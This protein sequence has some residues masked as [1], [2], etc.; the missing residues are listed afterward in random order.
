MMNTNQARE[1]NINKIVNDIWDK[2]LFEIPPYQRLYEWEEKQIETL[3]EDVKKAQKAQ[4]DQEEKKYFIGNIVVSKEKGRYVLIDGQQ[5]LTTLFL[6]GIYLAWSEKN[7]SK[8]SI[9]TAP[10][11][12]LD[13]AWSEKN[14][15]KWDNFIRQ[16]K[17]LRITMPLRKE[18]ERTLSGLID[19]IVSGE[20]KKFQDALDA[21]PPIHTKKGLE[22]IG[23]WFETNLK[24]QAIDLSKFSNF[25]YSNVCFAFVELAKGTDLNRFF[26]RMNNRGKQLEKHEIL[27][28]RLLSVIR[29]SDKNDN[30]KKDDWKK[31][32]KIWDLCSDMDKYIFALEEDRTVFNEE[33]DQQSK[34]KFEKNLCKIIKLLGNSPQ[35]QIKVT[36]KE[37]SQKLKEIIKNAKSQKTE[38][39]NP[40]DV[41]YHSIIDFPTFL[42]HCYKLFF[43]QEKC[44]HKGKE[45]DIKIEKDKLLG[46]MWD[47]NVLLRNAEN[48]K[49]FIENFLLYRF[50]FDYFIIKQKMGDSYLIDWNYIKD[51]KG[52]EL[53]G[54]INEELKSLVMV[55]NYLR[56]ARAGEKQNYHH[57]LSYALKLSYEFL[58]KKSGGNNGGLDKKAVRDFLKPFREKLENLDTALALEQMQENGGDL[59]KVANQWLEKET[60]LKA[61]NFNFWAL[62]HLN[63]GTATPHYWF[64]RLEYYLWKNGRS[65]NHSTDK[66]PKIGGKTFSKIRENYCFRAL[67]SV[68]HI[69]P[70][71]EKGQWKEEEKKQ[72][73]N[74]YGIDDFGNLALISR[75]FNSSLG[76]QNIQKKFVDVQERVKD[77][78]VESL[79]MCLAYVTRQDEQW[80]PETAKKHQSEMLD[81]LCE[82]FL[83]FFNCPD[84]F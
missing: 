15:S 16:N 3:L 17:T 4:K 8:K 75:N 79:K 73:Q 18:E 50:A 57:W 69:H 10:F 67:N 7:D 70:Q 29:E 71:S 72:G 30:T 47:E 21:L 52:R 33:Q 25:L 64:Y 41:T 48:A 35:N 24:N 31:Y 84:V 56:V 32:A 80:T 38:D 49:K 27:K 26:V 42:L 54:I 39:E 45:K 51:G 20:Q 46:Q 60:E 36:G 22:T 23:D 44:Q 40:K 63:Q 78:R 37:E 82:S 68:E 53:F 43:I 59:L 58:F 1:L 6:I 2:Y 14:D 77:N 12:L 55:Q 83:K 81:I 65:K 5:R 61:K 28:A 19:A 9:C 11:P 34:K 74:T 76:N 62:E 13:L 66:D